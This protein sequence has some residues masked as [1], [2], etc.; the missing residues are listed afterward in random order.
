MHGLVAPQHPRLNDAIGRAACW[1]FAAILRRTLRSAHHEHHAHP[2]SDDDPDFHTP[3]NLCSARALPRRYATITQ[4]VV[5]G[6]VYNLL[7]HGL[8]VAYSTLWAFW[9]CRRC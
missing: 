7:H 8:G 4:F 1:F 5:M 2:A 6:A 3:H 9:T